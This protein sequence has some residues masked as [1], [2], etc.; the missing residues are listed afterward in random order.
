MSVLNRN[1]ILALTAGYIIG[2]F[3][4]MKPLYC[5]LYCMHNSCNPFVENY[6]TNYE[7]RSTDADDMKMQE[8]R[9]C[10]I[11]KYYDGLRKKIYE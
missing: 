4:R 7:E 10:R 1:N 3:L 11:E 6:S 2:S 9:H 5:I 8:E